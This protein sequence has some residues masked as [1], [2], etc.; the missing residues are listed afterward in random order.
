MTKRDK[1]I[2]ALSPDSIMEAAR[3]L[4]R[5]G[6]VVLPSD[7]NY[8]IHCDYKNSDAVK[9]LY[10][11]KKR[12][13]NSPLLMTVPSANFIDRFAEPNDRAL[14]L[15]NKHWPAP[16]SVILLRKPEVP[17]FVVRGLQTVG[18]GCHKHLALKMLFDLR[19][20]AVAS[21]SAN[22]S[23]GP[24]PKSADDVAKQIGPGVDLII[25]GGHLGSLHANT[26]IDF[27]EHPPVIARFGEFPLEPILETLPDIDK[28]MT[29]EQYKIRTQGQVSE[30]W[31][32]T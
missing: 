30:V 26:L 24:D 1:R 11:A 29:S 15:V 27:S 8:C 19:P 14:E 2:R 3:I 16:F 4:D 23:G 31:N 17:S 20:E 5:G 9:R 7:T 25:D 12:N 32:T 13:G 28:T 18:L 22:M 21:S 10:E 6:L